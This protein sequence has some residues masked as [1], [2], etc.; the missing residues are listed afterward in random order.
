[1]VKVIKMTRTNRKESEN[2]G[3]VCNHKNNTKIQLCVKVHKLWKGKNWDFCLGMCSNRIARIYNILIICVS[4]LG[5]CLD[6]C[7]FSM[8]IY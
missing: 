8:N 7:K 4:F 6:Y 5:K 2:S 1:M 3:K